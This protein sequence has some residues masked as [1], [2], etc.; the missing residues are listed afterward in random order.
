VTGSYQVGDW[1]NYGNPDPDADAVWWRSTS[2]QPSGVSL[3]VSRYQN[4]DVDAAITEA[5]NAPDTSARDAAYRKVA[6]LLGE[7][8]AFIWLARVNWV[9]AASPRVNGMYAAAN[10]SLQTLG[11]KTWT[12]DLW[13]AGR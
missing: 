4:P 6:R 2:V 9:L 11:P 7:N 5:R 8:V 13:P 3:N 10:G 12:G 1:R